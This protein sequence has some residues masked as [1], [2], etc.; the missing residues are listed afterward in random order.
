MN[1]IIK[2]LESIGQS[3]SVHQNNEITEKLTDTELK[4]I[5]QINLD[6]KCSHLPGDDD[7]E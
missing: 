4:Q 6:L 3:D 7:E 5:N 2:V 1:N